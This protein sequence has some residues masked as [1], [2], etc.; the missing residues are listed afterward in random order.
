MIET[1]RLIP[2]WTLCAACLFVGQQSLSAAEPL[3][4]ENALPI[5]PARSGAPLYI[6]GELQYDR[7]GI[8]E[9]R[10]QFI[11]RD[12]PNVISA[13]ETGPMVVVN[14][15]TRFRQSI[16]VSDHALGYGL[17]EIEVA[18]LTEEKRIRLG[19][20]GVRLSQHGTW[21]MI[22]LCAETDLI[23]GR[24]KTKFLQSAVTFGTAFQD[25]KEF[26]VQ[27]YIPTLAAT[28]FPEQPLALC[29]VDAI[30]LPSDA[31]KRLS[32]R[33]LAA[34]RRWVRAGGA[35]CIQ[36]E[37]PIEQK[38]AAFLVEL[39]GS[40]DAGPFVRDENGV[41]LEPANTNDHFFSHRAGL[42]HA[43]IAFGPPNQLDFN[44]KAWRE[45]HARFW[46]LREKLVDLRSSGQKLSLERI[47]RSS[48]GLFDASLADARFGSANAPQ[49]WT[50]P[51]PAFGTAIVEALRPKNIRL[52][53]GW[54]IS[55]I[56]LGY[57]FVVGPLDYFVLGWLRS[58]KWTWIT[59]PTTT[60]LLTAT[61]VASTNSFMSGNDHRRRIEIVDLDASA[62]P[63]RRT[64]LELL[65]RGSSEPTL[66][67]I[68]GAWFSSLDSSYFQTGNQFGQV[69]ATRNDAS[70]GPYSGAL[71]SQYV[72]PQR[73]PK[74]T[75][76][77]NRTFEMAPENDLLE[78][79]W[80]Q[81]ENGRS[82]SIQLSTGQSANVV[83]IKN[84]QLSGPAGQLSQ[85]RNT[86]SYVWQNGRMV[87]PTGDQTFYGAAT[88][89]PNQERFAIQF[90]RSPQ[91]LG[92]LDDLPFL[93]GPYSGDVAV[94][95]WM[96]DNDGNLKIYRKLA[97]GP[98]DRSE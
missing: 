32:L 43:I 89:S 22:V 67:E 57:V 38:Q 33:Q 77:V 61:V 54:A 56:L 6:R 24:D 10:L 4:M 46:R 36:I 50:F 96:Q 19:E 90:Q 51:T 86:N 1:L 58:R 35:V 87:A 70:T 66:H 64:T 26:G 68:E 34:I 31:F 15:I 94:I 7:P 79:D 18:F 3:R 39:F 45:S 55:L 29:A 98:A 23:A 41:L 93:D 74:W 92:R 44:S 49:F 53:P 5:A 75:P 12:G 65:F 71:A 37:G 91:G 81:I 25:P 72:V 47:K 76:Q 80:A 8:L 11:L 63:V 82:T 20:I 16:P 9:G 21:E 60:L 14:G 84:G 85:L 30:L 27:D 88:S 78:I 48:A 62:A 42:G 97:D 83:R 59:F 73:V 2:L 28:E 13:V 69:K 17:S 95:V 52:M 40:S